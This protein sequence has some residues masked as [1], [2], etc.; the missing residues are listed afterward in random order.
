MLIA[1]QWTNPAE[2]SQ[3]RAWARGLVDA[4]RPFS[5]GAY[6]LSALD[7]EADKVINAAFGANL[8]RL[9]AIKKKY[10]PT[11]FFRVN[12]NIKPA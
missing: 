5:S 8:R 6:F 11:N 4:L 1:A 12:Q 10:D 9:A 7:Q 3:H 2:S